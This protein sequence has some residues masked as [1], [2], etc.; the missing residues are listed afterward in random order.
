MSEH[1]RSAALKSPLP[2]GWSTPEVAGDEIEIDGV[3]VVRAGVAVLAPTGEEI[4][5]S[6]AAIGSDASAVEARAWFELLERVSTLGAIA[7]DSDWTVRDRAGAAKRVVP[8]DELF[9]T[10]PEPDVW[11]HARSNG[12][13]L[14]A[15]WDE[16]CRR[17]RLELVERH[18]VL[19]AWWGRA[20]RERIANTSNGLVDRGAS[21]D[22][23]THRLVASPG[24]FAPDTEVVIVAGFPRD[25]GPM[26]LGF[27]ADESLASA[28]ERAT[29]EAIQLLAFLWGE[30]VAE[31]VRAPATD[32]MHH[33]E[34]YQ[35][36]VG[37]SVLRGWLEEDAQPRGAGMD[38]ALGGVEFVDLTPRWLDGLRVVK[39]IHPCALPLT[40]GSSPH[41]AGLPPERRLHPIP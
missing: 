40:F 19:E 28:K 30:P 33:L 35:T 7:R 26:A 2:D 10:S 8:S 38:R 25:G 32:A 17:A 1:V 18:R 27:G 20:G 39:A 34:H 6:A 5:G 4:T 41:M 9:R 11:R 36:T 16:A 23:R 15:T 3:S 12:V 13:A 22:W 21:H 31:E 29:G 37:Q 24:C 14:H